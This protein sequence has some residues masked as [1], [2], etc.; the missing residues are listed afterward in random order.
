MSEI[1]ANKAYVK[2]EILEFTVEVER[3]F[4]VSQFASEK[5]GCAGTLEYDAERDNY[6]I[7]NERK[8]TKRV[9]AL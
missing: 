3:G 7:Q 2:P 6:D 8:M 5:T 4:G 1:A 9:V